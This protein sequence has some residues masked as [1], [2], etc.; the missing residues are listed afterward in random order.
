M[1]SLNDLLNIKREYN[2]LLYVSHTC[3][4][5]IFNCEEC[6]QK[7]IDFNQERL[8]HLKFN[9]FKREESPG[10]IPIVSKKLED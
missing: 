5:L 1:S 8:D 4:H 10:K 2:E 6:L 9:I 3:S 7:E